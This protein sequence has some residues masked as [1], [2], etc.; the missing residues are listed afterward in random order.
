[1]YY[2]NKITVT[3][4]KTLKLQ[5]IERQW[6]YICLPILL[7]VTVFCLKKLLAIIN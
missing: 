6:K 2:F 5:A 1:M 7:R 3:E 4:K